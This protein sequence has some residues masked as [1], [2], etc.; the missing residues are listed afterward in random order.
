MVREPETMVARVVIPNAC[1]GIYPQFVGKL[2][3]SKPSYQIPPQAFG[4]TMRATQ[5]VIGTNTT[6]RF[7]LFFS[8]A[9]KMKRHDLERTLSARR[10]ITTSP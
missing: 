1:G 2:E 7:F 6:A 3:Q 4:M 5:T 10:A 8:S 9:V